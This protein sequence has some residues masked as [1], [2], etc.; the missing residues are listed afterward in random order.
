M[1][2]LSQ[3]HL[4]VGGTTFVTTK[5]TLSFGGAN[6]FTNQLAATGPTGAALSSPGSREVPLFIDRDA[7]RFEVILNFLRTKRVV[8]RGL[9][10]V[11]IVEEAKYFGISALNNARL[12]FCAVEGRAVDYAAGASSGFQSVGTVE[13]TVSDKS[14]WRGHN[15]DFAACQLYVNNLV[16]GGWI[17]DSVSE[18]KNSFCWVFSRVVV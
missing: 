11:E 13:G 12:E 5:E 17:I 7:K 2:Q 9:S 8:L 16:R 1:S 3:V 14:F 10:L 4:N 15:G 6:L 18:R